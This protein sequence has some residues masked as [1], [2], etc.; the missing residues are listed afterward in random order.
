MRICVFQSS[1]EGSGS[2]LQDIDDVPS[3]PGAFTSQHKFETRFIHKDKAQQEIDAAV[4][5]GF[6]F[7]FN[8]LWGTLDDPVAGVIASR[9]FESLGLPSCGIRSWER[10][11]TK[12]DFYKTARLHGAPLVPGVDRF[13]LFV[14]PANGCAS[15]LIDEHSV[16]HNQE[17]LDLALRR[18]STSLLEARIRRAH[19]LGIE[20]P[21]KYASSCDCLGRDSDDIVVQEYIEGRDY[22]CSVVKMGQSCIAL[23]P[24]VY[25]MK[26]PANKESFLTFDRKFDEETYTEL[27]QKRDNPM[28]FGRLQ[29]VAIE[30]FMVTDC[31]DSNMGCDVDL[32]ATPTGEVFAIE[33]NPQPATF[34]PEGVYQDLPII[35]SLP[36]GHPAVINI[37]IANY[38]LHHP[39]Q[40][41]HQSKVASEYDGFAPKYDT[42]VNGSPMLASAK[43]LADRFE[44]SGTVLDLGCGTGF[45]GRL[46]ADKSKKSS[47]LAASK[48]E[49]RLLGCDISPGMLETCRTS[50]LYDVLYLAS[51]EATLLK[52]S[53][54]DYAKDV[55]HITSFSAIHF[56]RPE[57]F[58][59][60]MVL[61][62]V[63]ANRSITINVDEIPDSYNEN[64]KEK[65]LDF[66]HSINHLANMEAFGEPKGWRLVSREREYSW[67]SPT[68]G[69]RVNTTYFRFERVDVDDRDVMMKGPELLRN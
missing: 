24:I 63:L 30:A 29:Q 69:D 37:F 47:S 18:I 50:G 44:F 26:Q 23:A 15:Q 43:R 66:M 41:D 45:F 62:F 39:G 20:D 36:G 9:Y 10:S 35:H 11:K 6:D 40:W 68:T 22:S 60:V 3:Q 53:N 2:V 56:L 14:K 48:Q 64:L 57:M 42:A 65:G 19:A 16:C 7:Y 54:S 25:N 5:E 32:R 67:T 21:F 12:N 17:E 34:L 4:A 51:M 28:L 46:L 55:D 59:F 31:K 49:S 33:V 27:L 1:Y 52:I 58:S 8:F 38:M 61:C 13:P